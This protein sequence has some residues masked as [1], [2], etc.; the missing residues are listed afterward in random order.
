MYF[1][2]F[3]Y[4]IKSVE[5]WVKIIF[6]FVQLCTIKK[7]SLGGTFNQNTKT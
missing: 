5:S 1:Y 4:V 6:L 3:N 2:N 7:I